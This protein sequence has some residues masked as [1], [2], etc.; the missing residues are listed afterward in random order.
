V[1]P[2]VAPAG[3]ASMQIGD[4]A[5]TDD[6]NARIINS[7]F[8]NGLDIAS[9]KAA[10]AERL[11]N[12]GQG[13]PTV[14]FRLR[15]WGVSRQRYWGCPIPVVHCA[16]CGVVAVPRTD[17]PVV[18][19]TDV[20]FDKPGNPLSHHPTWKHVSCPQ[21]AKPAE[22]ETDTFDTFVDSSW[23]FARFCSPR[24]TVPIN[25]AASDYWM[26]VDQY[27]GGVEHAILHLLYSRFYTRA[28]HATGYSNLDE[29][30]SGL[31]TQGM[32]THETYKDE[33]GGWL[34]PEQVIKRDGKFVHTETGA[35]VTVGKIESM[36]KSKRNV[37]D[38]ENI[39]ARYGADTARWFMISDTPPER[40]I[41]WT[42]FG[43]EGAWRFTQKIWRLVDEALPDLPAPGTE[44][45]AT[46]DGANLELRKSAH[47]AIAA[48]TDDIDKFRFNRAVARIYELSNSISG[49][50]ASGTDAANV[51]REALEILVQ[52]IAPMMPHLAEQCWAALGH[53]VMLVHT[54]WPKADPAML[55]TDQLVISVQVNGKRRGEFTAPP[56]T[57]S[58]TLESLALALEP[59]RK[60]MDSKPPRKVIVVP[61]RIVNVV[62]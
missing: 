8:L 39:I 57:A 60:H 6:H 37:V 43:V 61:D 5:Y 28:M 53:T 4:T 17:L 54:A 46:L 31:F 26:P 38:P 29:P 50:S 40:D 44:P 13:T 23:Y 2:V 15:D 1:L 18:L 3:E 27:I 25:R 35:P 33:T 9:A 56:G 49:F 14:N 22:R 36:S 41:E 16:D 30:F 45:G 42:E 52:L 24:A 51:R 55:H 10:V 32:V 34:F 7:D 11:S 19:P 12:A 47:L 58:A 21:C 62:V 59:V 20:S 48:V